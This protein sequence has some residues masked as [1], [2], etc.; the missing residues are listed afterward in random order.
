MPV[1]RRSHNPAVL[2]HN[3]KVLAI[4]DGRW[5]VVCPECNALSYQQERPI[6][7]G[8]PLKSRL[9]AERLRKNHG[10]MA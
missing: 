2:K 10:T 4:A 8:M 1:L 7:I 9:T 6:G 5:V 3:P